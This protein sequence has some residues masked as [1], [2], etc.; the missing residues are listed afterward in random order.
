MSWLMPAE[1]G[2][3]ERIWLAFPPSGP[4]TGETPAEEHSARS[5][6]AAVAHAIL[7]FQPVSMI[8]DPADVELSTE[9]LD[10]RIEI[11]PAPLDDAWMRD[12]GPSFVKND[13]GQLGAV[14]WHFNGW[15]QQGWAQWGKDSL[16]NAEVARLAG[17]VPVPARIVDEGGGFQ[18]DGEG[19]VLLTETV[20]LDP[21]R[22]PGASKAEI[23]SE[24]HELLDTRH[25]VW[26]PRSLARDTQALGTKGHV[27]I[28]ASIP[29]PGTVLLHDQQNPAHPDFEI[30][31]QIRAVFDAST[32]AAGRKWNIVAVPAPQVLEDE[33]GFVDFS[34]I[35]HLVINGAVIACTFNDPNDQSALDIL[36]EAYP[37][38][39]IIGVD[40]REIFA[41]GCGIH[42]I[43]QQQ[44]ALN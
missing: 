20:Q 12:I 40:A 17:A 41:R 16:I 24:V 29:A 19:T 28:V 39:Q 31:A 38:R 9:Y 34:Y 4:N 23:E 21:S 15:G 42:C 18:L 43:T 6:W 30:C 33:F 44:P 37:G 27:D 5:A 22:N 26:L 10:P 1:T 2:P 11:H 8:V 35:N 14:L 13:A 36:A 25:A 32:D 3:Q 7:P